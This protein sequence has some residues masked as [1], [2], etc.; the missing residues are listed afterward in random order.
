M[1]SP[2]FSIDGQEIQ[3]LFYPNGVADA[4]AGNCSLYV[5]SKESSTL[6]YDVV[7]NSVTER[8]VP[9]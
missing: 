1:T 6:A 9:R 8:S 5:L 3:L 2:S 4:Q 7:L